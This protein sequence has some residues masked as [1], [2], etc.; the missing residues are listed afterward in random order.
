M[1]ALSHNFVS[2]GSKGG[3]GK[4]DSLEQVL[5]CLFLILVKL[6]VQDVHVDQPVKH[7]VVTVQTAD[8][9]VRIWDVCVL[10]C[11]LY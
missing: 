11:K 8:L 1:K 5:Q 2:T 7:R 6:T 9:R 10:T 4:K 3:L